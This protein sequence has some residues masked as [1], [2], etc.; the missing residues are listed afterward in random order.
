M[1]LGLGDMNGGYDKVRTQ[2][3]IPLTATIQVT[4]AVNTN[5]NIKTYV[6]I[7][8]NLGTNMN[9]NAVIN[10]YEYKSRAWEPPLRVRV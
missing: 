4:S 2:L 9:T 7:S 1:F 5:I 8:M 6:T 10:K 3:L